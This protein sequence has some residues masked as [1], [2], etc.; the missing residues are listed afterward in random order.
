VKADEV[1]FV[2]EIARAGAGLLVDREK[3]YLIESRLGPVAR[4]EG[5]G[6]IR[7]MLVCARQRREQKLM[8]AV[9]EAMASGETCFFRERPAF[10]RLRQEVLPALAQ[11]DAV[12]PIRIW[13]AGCSTGQEAYSLAFLVEEAGAAVLSRGVDILGSDI[14]ECALE[15]AQA[16]LYTQFEVQRGMPIR[17]LLRHFERREE[18][19]TLSPRMRAM[20]RWRR[21]NLA[22]DCVSVGRFDVIFCRNV[23]SGMETTARAK[24]MDQLGKALSPGGYLA[25]GAGENAAGLGDAYVP[26]GDGLYRANPA[27]RAAA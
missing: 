19:W 11:A 3:V 13:S 16:G 2:A 21:V 23:L 14:S 9:I 25:L 8:W 12:G 6:S 15:K 1:E 20:V 18:L 26:L 7:E 4:R 10:D 17:L 22:T 5:F 24:A 27:F